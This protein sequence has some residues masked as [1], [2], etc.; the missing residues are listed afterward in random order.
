MALWSLWSS[1]LLAIFYLQL[2]AAED[3]TKVV[4]KSG[5]IVGTL[6]KSAKGS[7]AKFLGVRYAQ[8]PTDWLRFRAPLAVD[9][10][11]EE[12]DATV[13]KPSC[14]QPP[15]LLE[16]LHPVIRR[17][18]EKLMNVS[19][20]CLFLNIYVPK[21][22]SEGKLL[23][24]IVW[25]PGEGFDYAKA[26]QYDGSE[27][28]STTN[29]IIITVNY[30][31]S[32]FGFLSTG[33]HHA[34]GNMGL[35]DQQMALQWIHRNINSFG[36]DSSK[37]TLTGRF[38]GS[39]SIALHLVSP[40]N[41]NKNYFSGVVLQSGI[42]SGPYVFESNPGNGTMELAKA[43]GCNVYDMEQAVAC[44]RK[45][46]GEVLL[47]TA[48]KHRHRWAPVIDGT[49]VLEEPMEAVESGRY[50]KSINVILGMNSDEGSLC[51]I[52]HQF[53]KTS[54][55]QKLLDDQMT[56]EDLTQMMKTNIQDYLKE[57]PKGLESLVQFEYSQT[58]SRPHRISNRLQY[59]DFCGD[60]YFKAPIIKMAD[61]LS[62]QGSKVW[63]Y[64]FSHR[65]T[66]SIYPN[67]ISAA[68]GDDVLF[69]LGLIKKS[70]S[71]TPQERKLSEA[72]MKTLGNFALSGLLEGLEQEEIIDRKDA[73]E[74][75]CPD[76]EE[77]P[78][79]TP[80]TSSQG[81]FKITDISAK[82]YQT[83][84]VCSGCNTSATQQVPPDVPWRP[85]QSL[86][87]TFIK[88]VSLSSSATFTM[89][90]LVPSFC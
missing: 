22:K 68:H 56:S 27:L 60:M 8:A 33:D 2:S 70:E 89:Q 80:E 86:I 25:I 83:R 85:P 35:L 57:Q 28:A 46:D 19:E 54:Y 26:N 41:K 37:V 23:P 84:V 24:V 14:I 1:L 67:F 90:T 9:D 21:I 10:S 17:E 4:T 69:S 62:K 87:T 38:T 6:E 20:D 5:T 78:F 32:V 59:I 77:P 11:T 55:H 34:P 61:A 44:L 79:K 13:L 30:R 12:F 71:V 39:M 16:A 40:S 65:P 15:H 43:L 73:A 45:V 48:M 66:S 50:D 49:Y 58:C 76:I 74:G 31:V 42:P 64:E 53:L 63:M 88:S 52:M 3:S 29:S 7:L 75:R 81:V 47:N 18:E 36:G 82:E 72:M 51:L